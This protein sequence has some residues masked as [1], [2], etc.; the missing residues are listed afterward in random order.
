VLG[1]L[2]SHSADAA[3]VTDM[4]DAMDNAAWPGDVTVT[5]LSRTGDGTPPQATRDAVA[6]RLSD[7]T[8]RPLTDHVTVNGVEILPFEI[9]GTRYTYAGPDS[10]VV[11]AASDASLAAYLEESHRLGRDI[12]LSGL[13]AAIHVPGIQRV[14]LTAPAANIVVDR[15]QAAWCT[16]ID[17]AY[18]G[19]DE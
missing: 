17:L 2:A 15:T 18:G 14:D 1:V 10:D 8:V 16:A 3:L 12:T 19:T 4:T 7:K 9:R 5:V 6:A 11:L 13:D